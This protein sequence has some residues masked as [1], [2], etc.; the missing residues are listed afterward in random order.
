MEM[1]DT[2]KGTVY[3]ILSASCFA[4]L[5]I[6]IPYAIKG[7]SNTVTLMS[8]RFVLAA[9]VLW[10]MVRYRAL[11]LV[12][13]RKMAAVMLIGAAGYGV[14]SACLVQAVGRTGAAMAALLLYLYP[15]LVTVVTA[16]LG[17][18]K[19]SRNKL[20]ALILSFAGMALVLGGAEV[21]LDYVGVLF[22]LLS[23]LFYTFYITAGAHFTKGV[24][25]LLTTTLI[26][27]GAAALYVF[28]ALF[29]GQFTLAV[30]FSAWLATLGCVFFSTLL[31]IL[32]LFEAIKLIG[33]SKVSIISTIEPVITIALAV[34]LL[35][36]S[37]VLLQ[38]VGVAFVISSILI[39]QK[40]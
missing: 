6:F 39:L 25:P 30:S 34:V 37:F 32:F 23:S 2:L 19:F 31:S 35:G 7:G 29:S 11:P 27:S 16:A 22:G 17:M 26:V 21:K 18:E 1:S 5:A 40:Q 33:P 3:S 9:V 15:A 28:S 8:T 4:V 14:T 20:F 38:S 12:A 24:Q 10:S 13:P 36:E